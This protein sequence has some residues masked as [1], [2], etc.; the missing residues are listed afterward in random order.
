MNENLAD[1]AI[2]LGMGS[3]LVE[4]ATMASPAK[5][6]VFWQEATKAFQ[7]GSILLEMAG[8]L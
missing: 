3:D 2:L 4:A 8:D 5:A 6:A 7:L 1:A